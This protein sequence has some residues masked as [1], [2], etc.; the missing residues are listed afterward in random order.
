[1][2]AGRLLTWESR[3]GA[4]ITAHGYTVTPVAQALRLQ[5]PFG[6]L[7]W[8][9][10]VAVLVEE[11]G[12]VTRQPIVDV[13]RLAL[14]AMAGGTLLALMIAGLLGHGRHSTEE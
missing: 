6:G 11:G 1:M 12:A 3:E 4:A 5:T 2:Q 14:W 9:R 7:V 8:N 10:P 13:T